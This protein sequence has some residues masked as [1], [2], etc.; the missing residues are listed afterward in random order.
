MRRRMGMYRSQGSGMKFRDYD[1]FCGE[2]LI[3]EVF[4]IPSKNGYISYCP[5]CGRS[6]ALAIFYKDM[7]IFKRLKSRR[8]YKICSKIKIKE[9]EWELK[10]G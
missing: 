7:N 8:L 3:N 9:I 6:S 1:W 4:F 10:N 5:S 2:C